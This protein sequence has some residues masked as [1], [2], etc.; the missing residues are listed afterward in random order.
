MTHQKNILVVEDEEHL[1]NGIKYN[2]DAEGYCVTTIADGR[3]ALAVLE[4]NEPPINLL[5]LDLMLH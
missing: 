2:L 4:K 1:A 5:I 3:S